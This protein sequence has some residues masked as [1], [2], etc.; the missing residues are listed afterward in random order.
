MRFELFNGSYVGTIEW[1]DEGGVALEVPDEMERRFFERYFSKEDSF[2]SGAVDQAGMSLE[3]GD[4]SEQAFVRA[5][6]RLAAYRYR[7]TPVPAEEATTGV[8][9]EDRRSA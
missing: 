5:I 4:S 8:R 6:E 3:R 1:R 9:Q 7:A 2:M